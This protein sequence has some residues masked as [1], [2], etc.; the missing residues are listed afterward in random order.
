[1]CLEPR[2]LAALHPRRLSSAKGTWTGPGID[3]RRGHAGVSFERH[4]EAPEGTPMGSRPRKMRPAPR[5]KQR[6]QGRPEKPTVELGIAGWRV[7]IHSHIAY[8]WE[9]QREFAEAVGFVE[10]GL[11]GPEHCIV[12]GDRRDN[13]RIL[14]ILER[15]GID[16]GRIQKRKRLTV[17][18]RAATAET[19]IGAISEVIETALAVGAPFV[20]LFGAVGW[21]REAGPSDSELLAYEARLTEVAR[22]FPCVILCLHQVNALTGMIARHGVFGRHPQIVAEDGVLV[23]PFFIPAERFLARLGGIA[24]RLSKQQENRQALARETE[25]LQV[26]FDRI[27]VM[28]AFRDPSSRLLF[29][30][31]EWESTLGWTLKDA[32]RIDLLAEVYPESE[33][34]R[35]VLEL[36]QK[37]EHRWTDFRAR[38]RQGRVI[39]TSWMWIGLSDGTRIGF[40]QDTTERKRAEEALRALSERLQA[41]REE[42]GAR[43][44]REVHDEVGQALTALQMDTDWL[45]KKLASLPGRSREVSAKLRSMAA[46]IETTHD[47][48]QRIAT[49]LRPGVL[50][51][52]G[53][54]AALEWWVRDFE[55]RTGIACRIRSDLVDA[56]LD[57]DRSTAVFRILQEALTNVAR[58][59]GAT[60]VEIRL[61]ADPERL[62]V[63]V[64]DNGRGIS[65]DRIVDARSL[66]LL[67]MRERARSFGGDVTVHGEPAH[68]TTVT[69]TIPL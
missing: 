12:I 38:S 35:Q 32:Q 5:A 2:L 15:R 46:L 57:R 48:V 67:G 17:L 62:R 28:I 27:P 20:R 43:I 44:A 25:M 41:V 47:S 13:K 39:D 31:R 54:E 1:M 37:G 59:A 52:L 61:S 4:D 36:I 45:K 23:N 14:A 63:E 51:E 10:A 50:D 68:G 40:G 34:R 18:K 66:G 7:P 42:E 49:E 69:L 21:G 58:H 29:V 26:I 9:T 3:L 33:E 8:L 56:R 65:E 16:I 11:Q 22:R 19:M 53:L 24:A 55:Q 64:Q 30:N 6:A 60:Q